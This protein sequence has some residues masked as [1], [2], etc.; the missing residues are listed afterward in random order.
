MR[1]PNSFQDN[2][3]GSK[4]IDIAKNCLD[5][6]R[7]VTGLD[8]SSWSHTNGSNVLTLHVTWSSQEFMYYSKKIRS[9][10]IVANIINYPDYVEELKVAH[11]MHD[12]FK[13][14]AYSA[15]LLEHYGKIILLLHQC[16]TL[17]SEMKQIQELTFECTMYNLNGNNLIDDDL[18]KDITSVR[19]SRNKLI[20]PDIIDMQITELDIN[21]IQ[22]A[23]SRSI[24]ILSSLLFLYD[25]QKEKSSIT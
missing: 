21:E 16:I 4:S 23:S 19:N 25:K 22:N 17:E 6:I 3:D 12:F 24:E 10:P 13:V 15:T 9:L 2:I 14:L 11:E 7:S 20:H 1:I 8:H 5:D 18:Y